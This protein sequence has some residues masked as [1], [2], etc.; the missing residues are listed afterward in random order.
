MKKAVSSFTL[1][2]VSVSIIGILLNLT[3]VDDIR[4]FIGLN[5]ILNILSSSEKCC[6][7]INSVPYLWY[8]F[9]IITMIGYGLVLDG[10]K[11]LV[12]KQKVE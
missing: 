4:L 6:D 11:T 7:Y 12:K 1:W 9:S 3:G 5:P 2:F 10:I 8:A